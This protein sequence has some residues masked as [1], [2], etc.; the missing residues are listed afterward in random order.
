VVKYIR[1]IK[2]FFTIKQK[3][4]SKINQLKNIMYLAKNVIQNLAER[5]VVKAGWKAMQV[6]I[7]LNWEVAGEALI[8]VQERHGLPILSRKQER[9]VNIG[10]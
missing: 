2:D 9:K 4:E 10:N 7:F 1:N 5:K 3:G 6:E 8:F